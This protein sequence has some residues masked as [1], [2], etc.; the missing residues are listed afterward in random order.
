MRV[1][2]LDLCTLCPVGGRLISG[3]GDLRSRGKLVAHG[4]L[5][6]TDQHGLV[7]VDTGIGEDDR[8]D[9]KGRL[10]GAFALIAGV[11]EPGGAPSAIAQ[12]RAL[13]FDP[14][15]VRHIVCTHLD[16]DHAGGLPD[17]PWASV[18]VHHDERRAA[19]ARATLP[20]RE[21]YRVCHFSHGV[22]WETFGADGEAWMGF[23]AARNLK[24]LPP[25]I[26]GVPLAGHSRG[27]ACIA[28]EAGGRWLLHA[29]DAM[30]HRSVT[31]PDAPPM[32]TG[33]KYFEKAAAFDRSRIADNHRRLGELARAH[34]DDVVVFAAHDPVQFA[35]LAAPA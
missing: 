22:Q 11:S 21:R 10:G 2:H 27:H 1:H 13:G 24:G 6:E 15:D 4:L 18:H 30:F 32:P 8:R 14:K 9:P 12:V 5:I 34:R 25:E 19:E 23:S 29:G 31:E 17:F 33:L 26:V 16:L 28:V 35:R 20:E 3:E 7:L